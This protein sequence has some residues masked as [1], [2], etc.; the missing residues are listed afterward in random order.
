VS[1]GSPHGYTISVG[2]LQGLPARLEW[3]KGEM[4]KL[5]PQLG[6]IEAMAL[7]VGIMAPTAAMALNGSLAASITGTAVALAF[8]GAVITIMLTSYS[9][10]EFSRQFAHA[11]SVYVF[12]GISFGARM[13]FLSAWGLLLTY[14]AF[15]VASTAEVGLFFQTFLGLIGVN[16]HWLIPALVAAALIWFLAH[17][18][19]RFSTRTTL[20]VEALSV[21]L[22][23][24][25][26]VVILGR[27]GAHGLSTTPFEIPKVGLS[28][29]ALASVFG[30]LSFAGFEGAATLGE[31]TGNPK[32]AI[33]RA[34]LAAVLFTGTFYLVI[35]YTQAIGFG[36]DDKG[37]AAFAGSTSPLVDL[38][39]TYLGSTMAIAISLGATVSAFASALGTGLAASRLLFAL[40]RD[41]FGPAA[42]GNVHPRHASPYVAVATV[43]SIAIVCDIILVEQTGASV[44]AYAGTVGVLSLL[45]VYLATQ[46]GAIKLFRSIGRWRGAQPVI[47]LIAIVLLGYALYANV[48]PIPAAPYSYF[49]YGVLA[50]VAAG[51]VIVLVSPKLVTRIGKALSQVDQMPVDRAAAVEGGGE[52]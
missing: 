3:G 35:S 20:V 6:V 30:F 15:T 7:S 24:V 11:G 51:I 8:L 44:F 33:P 34:I 29:V 38:A 23:L 39:K 26:A 43:M 5:R 17:R 36:T 2:R 32:R 52:P 1:G 21:L 48:Y 41:G 19:V 49:P 12:N 27:G 22:I 47:P 16:V 40:G 9:F 10:I 14:T 45:L 37:V 42:L 28:A 4:S 46:V 50:W 31:E 25:L 18:E 13:G